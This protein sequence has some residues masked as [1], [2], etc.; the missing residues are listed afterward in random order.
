MQVLLLI[1][2]VVEIVDRYEA[3]CIPSNYSGNEVQFIQSNLNKNCPRIL[4]VSSTRVALDFVTD[5]VLF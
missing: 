3:D 5:G 4:R 1:H 2:Q